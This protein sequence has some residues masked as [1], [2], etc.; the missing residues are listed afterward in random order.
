MARPLLIRSDRS[1]YHVTSRCNNQEF[2]PLPLKEVW[3]IMLSVLLE[4]HK[5]NNLCI[6][7]FI[8][9]GNHFH[10]LCHTPDA[11]L[12]EAMRFFLRETSIRITRRV[13]CTNH[14]WGSRYRWSLIEA[15]AYYYQVYRYI[16]Q[17][18][19][20]ANIAKRVENY[21]F[22]TLKENVPF[23]LHTFIPMS[24]GGLKGELQWLNQHYDEEDRQLIK[25]G[26]RKNQFD[27]NRKKQK[28]FENRVIATDFS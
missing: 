20:R 1:P 13:H 8:L 15:Q 22:S 10:L 21:P 27:I 26:L 4:T 6:H 12:D 3:E 24:F 14:L 19:V 28:A 5:K 11:N 16:F 25:L 23:P 2:F 7:A 17:N 9:M 18:P